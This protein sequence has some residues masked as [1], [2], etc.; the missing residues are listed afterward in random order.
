MCNGLLDELESL[1]DVGQGLLQVDDVDAVTVGEDETLHL[2]VPTTGL[3]A[4][5]HTSVEELAHGYN[6]HDSL[7]FYS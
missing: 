1:I 3:V 4:E 6:C 5:V 2:R 7:A